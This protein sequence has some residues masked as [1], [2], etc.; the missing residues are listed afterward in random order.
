MECGSLP[1]VRSVLLFN[2]GF[3]VYHLYL[4]LVTV[5]F[6]KHERQCRCNYIAAAVFKVKL[7]GSGNIKTYHYQAVLRMSR[8]QHSRFSL[9][10][11]STRSIVY[12]FT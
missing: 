5:L 12:D 1:F 10:F 7:Q 6:R 9:C 11:Q 8:Q 3:L 2:F 4:D